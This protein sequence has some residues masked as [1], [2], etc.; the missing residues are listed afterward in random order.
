[1]AQLVAQVTVN[2]K[3]TGPSPVT[4]AMAVALSIP[5]SASGVRF[6][7]S[8]VSHFGSLKIEY[9]C[10][11]ENNRGV[12]RWYAPDFGRLAQLVERH[13]YTVKVTGSNPVS[14]TRKD[15]MK[16]KVGRLRVARTT[17]AEWES[18]F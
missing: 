15:I 13:A 7:S 2:H 12:P 18:T 6:K 1:M 17:C 11:S 10:P 5:I 14:P 3:V 8:A 4:G 9:E 16:D